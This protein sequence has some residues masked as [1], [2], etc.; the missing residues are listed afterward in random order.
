MKTAG[1]PPQAIL[2][3]YCERVLQT[4]YEWSFSQGTLLL[5]SSSAALS[6]NCLCGVDD[7]SYTAEV[8]VG[9]GEL[10]KQYGKGVGRSKKEAKKNAGMS[11]DFERPYTVY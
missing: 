2:H 7:G 10:R 1:R 6:I 11:H 3:D 4:V 5:Q 9:V 8:F